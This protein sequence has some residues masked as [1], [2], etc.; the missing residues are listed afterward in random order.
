MKKIK[1]RDFYE[2]KLVR[3]CIEETNNLL[4]P[5]YTEQE[6]VSYTGIF[7]GLKK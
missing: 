6:V 4:R 2:H 3:V 1:G 7:P 5:R